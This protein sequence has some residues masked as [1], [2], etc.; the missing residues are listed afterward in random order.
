MWFED[1]PCFGSR[2]IIA[3]WYSVVDEKL[4]ADD[5]TSVLKLYEAALCL[6]LHMR[7][8]PSMKQVALDSI[9]YSEDLF[10][11]NSAQ[12]DA[13]LTFAEKVMSVLPAE[14]LTTASVKNIVGRAATLGISFHGSAVGDGVARALINVAPFIATEEFRNA[15]RA[16]EEISPAL[17]DQTKV[18]FLTSTCT[19]AFGKSGGAAVGAACSVL[20]AL[21]AGL[22]YKDIVK[23]SHL[24]KE[25]LTGGRHKA[26]F[27]H[28]FFKRSAFIDFIYVLVASSTGPLVDEAKEKI[29]P[30]L[31]SVKQV[32]QHFTKPITQAGSADGQVRPSFRR[33]VFGKMCSTVGEDDED[34]PETEELNGVGLSF[35]TMKLFGEFSDTLSQSGQLL[36]SLL[37]KTH[38]CGFD[39]EFRT[40]AT[41]ELSNV[42]YSFSWGPLFSPKAVPSKSAAQP[43]QHKC[44][45]LYIPLL[46]E[47]CGAWVESTQRG[48]GVS[49][50]AIGDEDKAFSTACNTNDSIV[51]DKRA[52]TV[53]ALEELFHTKVMLTCFSVNHFNQI[54]IMRVLQQCREDGPAIREEA[55]AKVAKGKH[56]KSEGKG[57][58]ASTSAVGDGKSPAKAKVASTS[59]VG[60]GDTGVPSLEQEKNGTL[61]LCCAELFLGHEA[62]FN[63][64]TFRGI[65]PSCSSF[66]KELVKVLLVG[67]QRDDI[68]LVS[69]GR[70]ESIRKDIR[71][72]FQTQLREEEFIELWVIYSLETSLRQDVR[73]PKR[74]LAW[75]SH[76]ME[77]LFVK[78]PLKAKGQ[79]KLVARD[80]FTKCGESTNFS[81]SYTGVPFR[82]I[83]E[84]PRLTDFAKRNILGNA[85][86]GASGRERVDKEV[87]ERGH[88]LMWGEWKPVALYSTIIRD[89]QVANVVDS[90]PGSGAACLASLY[91]KVP[92]S[93]IAFNEQHETWLRDLLQKLFVSMVISN[94]VVA[95][96]DLVKNASA[97]LNRSA[98]VAVRMLPNFAAVIG[99]SLTGDDDS[100][101]DEITAS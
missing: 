101:A 86:V 28:W 32:V 30:K 29:F 84:I 79:R 23:E 62:I 55:N 80:R 96:A 46:L 74:K 27:A 10:A 41:A 65:L 51:R 58:E 92:Y 90:T 78:L 36:A 2:A 8:G 45:G 61:F 50:S 59:A 47:A 57:K 33:T 94:D 75:S 11:Y 22:L 72:I 14:F 49:H 83:A 88:P 89:F 67:A 7:L 26:G 85:A 99:D 70:S 73:N 20:F 37:W 44:G 97:Y 9:T 60:D 1:L 39:E 21:R 71:N 40:I 35:A 68:V 77:T 38:G 19:K 66:F 18:S 5:W 98:E 17:N 34:E 52:Q 12:S 24:T 3:G 4:R 69:D 13:F 64:E 42:Q 6:P 43:Q 93:G 100:D 87:A 54:T 95:N 53:T 15:F 56:D 63:R 48:V 82:N 81:R 25:Y 91:S 76:N 16:F 31:T